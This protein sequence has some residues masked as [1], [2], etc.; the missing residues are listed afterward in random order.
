QEILENGDKVL[1]TFKGFEPKF[2]H[3]LPSIPEIA[4][5]CGTNCEHGKTEND[6]IV[7]YFVKK[8]I[9]KNRIN[10]TDQVY[11]NRIKHEIDQIAYNGKL[12]ILPYFYPLLLAV[13][14]AESLGVLVGPGRGSAAGSLFAYALGITNVDPIKEDL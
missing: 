11:S 13:E 14:Q 8:I 2:S 9:E 3:S 12:N 4:H 10:M 5:K 6:H 7:E 1:D